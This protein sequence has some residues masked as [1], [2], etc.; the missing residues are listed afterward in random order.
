MRDS[1]S[2][3]SHIVCA[4]R[5]LKF[6]Q[7]SN[8]YIARFRSWRT[9]GLQL[10]VRHSHRLRAPAGEAGTC[11]EKPTDDELNCP[12]GVGRGAGVGRRAGV[13]RGR[14]V[15]VGL[16]VTVAVAV[17]VGVGVGVAVGVGVTIGVTVG[18]GVGVTVGVAVGVG[19]GVDV[20]EGVMLGV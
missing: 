2:P 14:G 3:F 1:E 18:V 6:S 5:R 17:A 7:K 4:N 15:G 8:V 10:Y 16:G 13:G 11:P 19:V 12:E 20:G 9:S